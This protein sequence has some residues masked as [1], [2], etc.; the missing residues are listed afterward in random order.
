MR[1]SG[2]A[3]KAPVRF[4]P[5]EIPVRKPAVQKHIK[6]EEHEALPMPPPNY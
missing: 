5:E 4:E 6:K 1:R 2:R 3:T